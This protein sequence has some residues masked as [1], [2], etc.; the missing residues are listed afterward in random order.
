MLES[1]VFYEVS[2]MAGK[3]H[4]LLLVRDRSTISTYPKNNW[5]PARSVITGSNALD[6]SEVV[7]L[8]VSR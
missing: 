1:V 2:D 8:A 7:E 4:R 3:L 6:E 5:T